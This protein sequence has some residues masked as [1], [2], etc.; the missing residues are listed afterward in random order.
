MARLTD[1]KREIILAGFHLG[2]SQHWLAQKVD[3]KY[4][5]DAMSCVDE[6]LYVR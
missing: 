3:I 4:I 2:K 5:D 6:V 1:K